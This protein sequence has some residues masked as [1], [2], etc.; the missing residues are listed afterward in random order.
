MHSLVFFFGVNLH[1]SL[2]LVL[3]CIRVQFSLIVSSL[4]G[5]IVSQVME[6]NE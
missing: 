2:L 4:G 1:I 6:G 3:N 5:N